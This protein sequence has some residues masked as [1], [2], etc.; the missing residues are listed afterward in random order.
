MVVRSAL[1]VLSMTAWC[2]VAGDFAAPPAQ[3]VRLNIVALDD[4]NQP[5][6]DLSSAEFQIFDR[7]KRQ[8]IAL[9]R[10]NQM[11]PE[12]PAPP[13]PHTFS[14]RAAASPRHATVILFDLLNEHIASLGYSQQQLIRALQNLDSSSDLYLYLLTLN[15]VLYPIRALPGPEGPPPMAAATWTHNIATLLDRA[16]REVF[17]ARPLE[18]I[19]DTD[20]RVRTTYMALTALSSVLAGFPGRKSIVWIT[21]GIPIEIGPNRSGTPDGIDYSPYLRQFTAEFDHA[22]IA[23]YPVAMSPRIET[24][25]AS[26]DTVQEFAYL[27]GGRTYMQDIRTA[28]TEAVDEARVGY[29]IEYDPSPQK[30]DGKFH[31]IRVT[32]TRPKV[33]IET[34]KGYY[35]YP[36][37]GLS[38]D[39]Q[40]LSL[41]AAATSPFDA[42]EI[43]LRVT[44]LPG[45]GGPDTR[46]LH[47]RLSSQDVMWLRIEDTYYADLEM[48]FV[49]FGAA[50]PD[51]ASEPVPVTLRRPAVP[52]GGSQQA[53]VSVNQ[54]LTISGT[55]RKIRIVVLDR[56]S[57]AVGSVTVPV[58]LSNNNSGT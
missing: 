29:L 14:N 20:Y 13:E 24:G 26:M 32:C 36:P 51:A 44:V 6:R 43:G 23:V 37:Q 15:G 1:A 53:D 22:N 17:I 41:K 10:R 31:K 18:M 48:M 4:H 55:T 33:R 27:T 30:W 45:A 57:D 25:L 52:S 11:K 46:R 39:Q 35:A 12:D 7:G 38:T 16:V 21:H 50:G 49:E 3:L 19:A 47:I 5:V 34:K 40:N 42:A 8:K 2:M 9:F 58:T 54:D 56:D 28:V